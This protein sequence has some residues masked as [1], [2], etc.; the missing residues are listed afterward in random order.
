M[1]VCGAAQICRGENHP[2]SINMQPKQPRPKSLSSAKDVGFEHD[3]R[4]HK[5]Q[6]DSDSNSSIL[7]NIHPPINTRPSH[8]H[9]SSSDSNHDINKHITT[10]IISKPSQ[11]KS[12][13]SHQMGHTPPPH[14]TNTKHNTNKRKPPVKNNPTMGVSVRKSKK[15]IPL[16]DNP[17]SP[18]IIST[19]PNMKQTRSNPVVFRRE[20]NTTATLERAYSAELIKEA[21]HALLE[22]ST[23]H[24]KIL[25][26]DTTSPPWLV[27]PVATPSQ[28]IN[29]KYNIQIKDRDSNTGSP[30]Y[31][32]DF[33]DVKQNK[34]NINN[35]N[36]NN[37]KQ[38]ITHAH[39]RTQSHGP[40]SNFNIH[41]VAS[42]SSTTATPSRNRNNSNNNNYNY[43]K[44]AV[45]M[46]GDDINV[47]QIYTR[48]PNLSMSMGPNLLFPGP[49]NNAPF[50]R[51]SSTS[52]D[53]THLIEQDRQRNASQHRNDNIFDENID[54]NWRFSRGGSMTGNDRNN[55]NVNTAGSS[56]FN[57]VSNVPIDRV[58]NGSIHSLT[59]L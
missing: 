53:F 39:T 37:N 43:N 54:I 38:I 57:S 18:N 51:I 30:A 12:R 6:S 35:N 7:G 34:R 50:P 33:A 19:N 21:E 41:S 1:G 36:N 3:Q 22:E 58:E 55:L 9:H 23:V 11:T 2:K 8:S 32:L 5:T 14:N 40:M 10:K 25:V 56:T 42:Q 46:I 24:H 17:P 13:N 15:Y 29:H 26:T 16:P 52:S 49:N 45:P 47:N 20:R 48:E 44:M 59:D 27:T 28:N 4:S 31:P